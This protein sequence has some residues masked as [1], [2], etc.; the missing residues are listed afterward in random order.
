MILK[1]WFLSPILQSHCPGWVSRDTKV[2]LHVEASRTKGSSSRCWNR[3]RLEITFIRDCFKPHYGI[4]SAV[5]GS[6]ALLSVVLQIVFPVVL[7]VVWLLWGYCPIPQNLRR[8]WTS[9]IIPYAGT[10]WLCNA[11]PAGQVLLKEWSTEHRLGGR[12]C[13][14]DV[15]SALSG[16]CWIHHGQHRNLGSFMLS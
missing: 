13:A 9:Q 1:C 14:G 15:L 10:V 11:L 4:V 3:N 7:R 5:I 8:L 16:N 6:G 12:R 2:T